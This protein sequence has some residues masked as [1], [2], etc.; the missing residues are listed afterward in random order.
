[1][2]KL[3]A[4]SCCQESQAVTVS[5][6]HALRYFRTQIG[7]EQRSNVLQDIKYILHQQCIFAITFGCLSA[8][9][10]ILHTDMYKFNQSQFQGNKTTS[11]IN[12]MIQSVHRRARSLNK[13]VPVSTTVRTSISTI[14]THQ[15]AEPSVCRSCQAVIVAI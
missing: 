14:N 13:N 5:S 12:S 10:T 7:L 2:A 1:M 15:L 6:G 3:S 8:S 11:T 4:Q 9:I